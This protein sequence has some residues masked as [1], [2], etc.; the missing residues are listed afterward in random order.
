VKA[1]YDKTKDDYNVISVRHILIGTVNP[2]TGEETRK[3]ADALKR[4]QEVKK[5]LDAGGDWKALAKEYSDDTGSKDNGG[6]YENQQ[7]KAWVAEFK[8]AANKQPIG[9]IGEP[10][11]SSYGYHVMEVLKREP[12]PFDKLSAEDKQG[13]KQ[14]VASENMN[15][16]M[17]KE[18][19]G[20][21]TKIDLPQAEAPKT[22]EG[23]TNGATNGGTNGAT[24]GAA[25]T[26]EK[27]TE[28][29]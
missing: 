19:P 18:L 17:T 11:K 29:K 2:Q 14:A 8:D 24:N 1:Q 5:K 26:D 16:F 4:A 6:L 27:K 15:T 25:K 28:T 23:A 10:V 22:G 12:T 20:L 7:A 3:D 9:K 13:L 21:I